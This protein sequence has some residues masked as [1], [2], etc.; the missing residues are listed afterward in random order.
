MFDEYKLL[1]P[2]S[3]LKHRFC[4]RVFSL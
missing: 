1:L 3:I 4:Q 2:D